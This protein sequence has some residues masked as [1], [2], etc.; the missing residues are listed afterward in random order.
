MITSISLG[1]FRAFKS[2]DVPLSKLNI[3][4]GP[5]NS[6][7]S[8]IISAVNLIAQNIRTGTQE[9]TLALNGPYA[10]LGTFYDAVHGHSAKPIMHIGFQID[11]YKYDYRYRYR[12]QRREI[13][14]V[15]ADISGGG[16]SYQYM[17]GDSG[18]I[19]TIS[20]K[21]YSIDGYQPKQRAR[22]YGFS[23]AHSLSQYSYK[24]LVDERNLET[25][26][27]LREFMFRSMYTLE[28]HF[29]VFDSVGAFRA[30]PQR[31][32]HYTGEAPSSVGKQGEN[33]AQML[34]SSAA[35]RSRLVISVIRS[36]AKWFVESGVA[37][38]VKIKPLTNRHFEIIVE[39]QTGSRS[40]IIDSGFG[41]SQ[42]LPVL[43]GGFN[44][45]RS[46]RP[47]TSAT[48][49]VQEPE[50][51]LHPTAAAH[52]GTYFKDLA[53]AG[54]Q[55][56]VE[57]HSENIVLRVARHVALGELSPDD[58]KIYW[59]SA[60]TGKHEVTALPLRH[61]G[62]FEKPWPEGFFPTRSDETLLLARAASKIDTATKAGA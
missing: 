25:Y 62:T 47:G 44:L 26:Q 13:E 48:F 55:C 31:T 45:V 19:Q 24:Q 50:I 53:L 32:Y 17:T 34:A 35:S 39:D 60:N 51:H 11:E 37:R 42:A 4:V 54:V 7:K 8:S 40:N 6:G 15:R 5:N 14:L 52:M 30:A 61:D 43:A 28:R 58:V 3:F 49:V 29:S 10:E 38:D 59:V 46:R 20:S 27:R 2:V 18:A 16:F 41:C 21:L 56:F 1:N 33:F 12:P 23:F 9:F 57:T 36:A 22:I